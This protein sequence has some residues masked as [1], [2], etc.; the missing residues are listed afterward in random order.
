MLHK[1]LVNDAHGNQGSV[2]IVG[3]RGIKIG[4][5]TFNNIPVVTIIPDF[6]KCWNVEG[7]VGSNVLR[8]SIVKI[9][10][11]KHQIII[12]DYEE[13]LSLTNKTS[14]PLISNNDSQT[15]PIIKIF[16]KGKVDLEFGFD[17][18]DPGFLLLPENYIGQL[19]LFNVFETLSTGYGANKLGEFGLQKN[20]NT[21]RLKIDFLKIGDSRFDN[22]ITETDKNG[23]PRIGSKLL[24]YG[25]VTID[26]IH[27]KFY[28]DPTNTEN[29]LDEKKWPIHPI[30]KGHKLL[31]GTVWGKLIDQIKPGQQI[32][33][34]D[35]NNYDQVELCNWVLTKSVFD[36]KE[37]I[38][39]AIKDEGGKIKTV[40]VIKE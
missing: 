27:N 1:E 20:D 2:I 30:I 21:Y 19:N 9:V 10:P 5:V 23:V 37:K 34:I 8:N 38:K 35:D 6:L 24:D 39:L 22:V 28:F 26:F 29:D 15:F 4:D 13:K 14:I 31:V 32:T 11:A 25:E 33:A 12:T 16:F 3:L 17:T 18:G 7:V 40:Q 36:D